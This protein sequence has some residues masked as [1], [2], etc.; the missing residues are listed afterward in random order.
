[1]S[2]TCRNQSQHR[3]YMWPILYYIYICYFLSWKYSLSH[4]IDSLDSGSGRQPFAKGTGS[5]LLA[6]LNDCF[7]CH[8]K[9][10]DYVFRAFLQLP[11]S[12]PSGPTGDPEGSS[13]IW[14][15]CV[16]A[17][18]CQRDGVCGRAGPL[19]RQ[20][21]HGPNLA[22]NA[23]PCYCQGTQPDFSLTLVICVFCR[24]LSTT[25]PIN[26]NS[27]KIKAHWATVSEQNA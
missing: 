14:E 17:H 27:F 7:C 8:S 18:C 23:Q 19:G 5:A 3:S 21:H 1:M 15:G 9:W 10:C 4:R 12:I 20:E 6:A 24:H 22:G 11:P 26:C 13:E 25:W 16:H 2:M